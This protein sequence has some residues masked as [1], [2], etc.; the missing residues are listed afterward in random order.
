MRGS[1]VCYTVEGMVLE[2][3]SLVKARGRALCLVRLQKVMEAL[4]WGKMV[5]RIGG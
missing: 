4:G 3:E 5:H 1:G 2:Q